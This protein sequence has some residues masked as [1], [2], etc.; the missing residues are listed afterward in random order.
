[1]CS[2]GTALMTA[3]AAMAL[4]TAQLGAQNGGSDAWDEALDDPEVA[5]PLSRAERAE[6]VERIDAFGSALGLGLSTR[7]TAAQKRHAV[8]FGGE[9]IE[10]TYEDKK[11]VVLNHA[12]GRLLAFRNLSLEHVPDG[13]TRSQRV[14][15][16]T[17][18]AA[19]TTLL[20]K[21]G[22]PLTEAECNVQFV[23]RAERKIGDLFGATWR[24][25]QEYSYQGIPCL[26]KG[27]VV[28]VSAYSGE[29]RAFADYPVVRPA[30]L[31]QAVGADQAERTATEHLAQ[32]ESDIDAETEIAVRL[33]I[34]QPKFLEAVEA[35]PCAAE[36]ARLAW[37]VRF[38]KT[39]E[40]EGP[41][42][43]H[44]YVDCQ[45][46]TVLGRLY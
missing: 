42:D 14:D 45:S 24:I 6:V 34:V 37:E 39:R 21:L 40:G 28:D 17:A 27:R 2:S 3:Y 4:L 35:L 29:V 43:F 33:V 31:E 19:A 13:L 26:L 12:D 30:T 22:Q 44:V 20:A 41:A 23:D 8:E 7:T 46:G 11:R 1:M 16:V 18:I 10:V 38:A 36:E 9:V 5:G 32:Y 15:E 25:S